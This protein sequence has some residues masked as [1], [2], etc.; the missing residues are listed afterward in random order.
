MRACDCVC[1]VS[2]YVSALLEYF[3]ALHFIDLCFCS[4]MDTSQ[5]ILNKTH[6]IIIMSL[7]ASITGAD[8]EF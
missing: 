4:Q 1:L 3:V 6:Y 8:P 7:Q 2:S 5:V